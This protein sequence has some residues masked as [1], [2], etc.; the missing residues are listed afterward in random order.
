MYLAIVDTETNGT[1]ENSVAIEKAIILYHL[2][3]GVIAQASTLLYHPDE[4]PPEL[5]QLT[6]IPG[7]ALTLNAVPTSRQPRY[8]NQLIDQA[9]VI[10][11]HKASFDKAYWTTPADKL[12]LCTIE[13][14]QLATPTGKRDLVSLA[15]HY[16]VAV[17][18]A[19]R[20]LTDCQLLASIFD[21]LREGNELQMFI[22]LAI[23][24][25]KSP[26]VLVRLLNTHYDDREVI[27]GWRHESG[28]RFF[29]NP[30]LRSWEGKFKLIDLQDAT[31]PHPTYTTEEI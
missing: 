21:K 17:T 30:D 19:H 5:E 18:S 27:K 13:D 24:R 11:A 4:L 6:G 16:G 3:F 28:S 8:F 10:V 1:D 7:G 29:W 9:D 2:E 14:F 15:L 26:T 25:A 20:A 31:L 23:E 12:W 22:D